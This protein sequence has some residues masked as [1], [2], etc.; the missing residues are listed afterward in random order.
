MCMY[1]CILVMLGVWVLI[2]SMCIASVVFE[3]IECGGVMHRDGF[4][5][6]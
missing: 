6:G 4:A 3:D 2:I 1:R 5:Q